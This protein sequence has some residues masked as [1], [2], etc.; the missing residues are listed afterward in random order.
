MG[1]VARSGG[2]FG[3]APVGVEHDTND[4]AHDSQEAEPGQHHGDEHY[5]R[6][7]WW[8]QPGWYRVAASPP[9]QMWSS[10]AGSGGHVTSVKNQA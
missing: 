8:E 4:Y 2:G 5:G 3:S 1:G 9:S 10:A 7:H 6:W